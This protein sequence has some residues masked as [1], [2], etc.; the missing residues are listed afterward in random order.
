MTRPLG[1]AQVRGNL[2]ERRLGQALEQCD[3]F[4]KAGCEIQLT[5]HCARGNRTAL[6][7]NTRQACQFVDHLG[8]N[9]GGVHVKGNEAPVTAVH[10]VFLEGE[11]HLQRAGHFQQLTPERGYIGHAAA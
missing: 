3:P 5:S 6:L 9:Q 7:S 10:V 1:N 2:F 8:L 11:V 4:A